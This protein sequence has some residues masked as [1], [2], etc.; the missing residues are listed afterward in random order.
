MNIKLS[1]K[2]ELQL[3]SDFF[4]TGNTDNMPPALERT[5]KIW[6][7]A[8][9]ILLKSPY[10]TTEKIAK[11]LIIEFTDEYPMVLST[12]RKHVIAAKQFFDQVSTETPQ[13]HRR[14][15]VN[16]LY[17][18]LA[19]LQSIQH[20]NVTQYSK[21]IDAVVHRISMLTDAYNFNT[22][23]NENE[24][25]TDMMFIVSDNAADFPDMEEI[26]DKKLFNLIDKLADTVSLTEEQK[27]ELIDKDIKGLI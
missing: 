7:R 9:A 5:M 14:I 3:M 25:D 8:D 23:A 10:L 4:A 20:H 26:S 18:Q 15:L 27:Q 12:A 24:Y 16:I 1:P 11:Q 2:H 22:D 6:K 19:K 13:T 21:Q 17:K